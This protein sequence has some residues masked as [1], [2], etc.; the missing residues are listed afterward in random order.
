[1]VYAKVALGM[2]RHCHAVVISAAP[3]A[4]QSLRQIVWHVAQIICIS[5]SSQNRCRPD[6]FV[7]SDPG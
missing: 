5:S 3:G 4:L 7:G 2:D 6:W 1:M